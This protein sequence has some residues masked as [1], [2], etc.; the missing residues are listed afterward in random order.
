[1]NGRVTKWLWC[2]IF[3]GLM[4]PSACGATPEPSLPEI[5]IGVIAPMRGELGPL[6]GEPIVR[7][8]R[9]LF[10]EINEA[11]GLEV[12]GQRYRFY[13]VARDDENDPEVAARVAMELINQKDVVALVGL[14]LSQSA[15]PVAVVADNA[16]IPV[17]SVKSTSPEI[18]ED[19]RCVFRT[20][21]TDPFQGEV[22]ARFAREDLQIERAAVLFDAAGAYNRSVTQLFRKAFEA[23]GGQVVCEESYTSDRNEDFTEQLARVGESGAQVLLLPN[24]VEDVKLQVQQARTLGLD[25]IFLGSDSWN[26]EVFAGIPEFEGAYLY[27]VWHPGVDTPASDTFILAYEKVYAQEPPIVAATAYDAFGLLVQGIEN[28]G[29]TDSAGICLGLDAIERYWGVTGE[30]RYGDS[31]DPVRSAVILRIEDGRFWFHKEIR[32]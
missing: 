25:V 12:D 17:I 3:V 8:G 15:I 28:S 4:L 23:Q 30:L 5:R 10:D 21:A 1:M 20:V 2:F 19:K 26:P 6:Y 27:D 14:P 29:A 24:Y 7:A 13:L 11:G 9:L 18:T 31:G 32:P 22:L 16:G